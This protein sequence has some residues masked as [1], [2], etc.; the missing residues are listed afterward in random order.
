[1]ARYSAQEVVDFVTGEE[2]SSSDEDSVQPSSTTQEV[3]EICAEDEIFPSRKSEITWTTRAEDRAAGRLPARHILRTPPGPTRQC[4]S[5]AGD[6]I[7]AFK[8]FLP[9]SI[10]SIVVSMT[11]IEGRKRFTSSWV[12]MTTVELDAFIGVCILAGVFK[13]K[14]ESVAS[15]WESKFG[16]PIFPAIMSRVRFEQLT[17]TLR[18]DDKGSW[19]SRRTGDKLALIRD[20]WD[21]RSGN[22][23]AMYNLGKYDNLGTT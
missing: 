4:V 10:E 23:P 5:Q 18:F 17:V 22:L 6:I 13:S 21:L 7:S 15:L 12:D 16:R 14:G 1:M 9:R 3:E 19:A 20:I 8:A 2:T 11:N